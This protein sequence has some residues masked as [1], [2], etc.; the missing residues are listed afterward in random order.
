MGYKTVLVHCDASKL[1]SHR[2]VVAADLAQRFGA[3]LVGLH[4][5]RP[6]ETSVF[7]DSG[8]VTA[9]FIKIYDEG[10]EADETRALAAFA[11]A[12]APGEAAAACAAGLAPPAGEG[13]SSSFG[14]RAPMFAMSW[15]MRIF[16]SK[17]GRSKM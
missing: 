8:Y 15:P 9:D 12:T 3:C 5:R 6:L 14:A 13:L 17:A 10:V 7:F 2:L 4:V 1:V 16:P 11:E